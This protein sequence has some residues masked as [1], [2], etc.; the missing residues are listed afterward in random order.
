MRI[1]I[2]EDMVPAGPLAGQLDLLAGLG[3]TGIELCAASLAMDPDDLVRTFR[4]APVQPSAVEGIPLL[5]S[6]DPKVR[7]Q[8]RET[9]RQ[10]LDLAGRARAGWYAA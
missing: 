1:A 8:A 5:T 4:D 6:L 7:E 9:T 3:I 10:R 2:R